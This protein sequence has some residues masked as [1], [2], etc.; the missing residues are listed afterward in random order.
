M[1]KNFGANTNKKKLKFARFMNEI[2]RHLRKHRSQ[3]TENL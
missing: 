1:G 2:L 3:I